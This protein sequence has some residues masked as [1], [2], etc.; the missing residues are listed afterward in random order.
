V[1]QYLNFLAVACFLVLHSTALSQWLNDGEFSPGALAY[2]LRQVRNQFEAAE[3]QFSLR[4]EVESN[5]KKLKL[6]TLS[7]SIES[8]E[9]EFRNGGYWPDLL[10]E[11]ILIVREKIR[12]VLADP[13]QI[14]TDQ[15]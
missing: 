13:R 4:T 1:R 11:E 5:A 12:L 7:S 8:L 3:A 6:G 9:T 2:K 15:K 10:D 14:S